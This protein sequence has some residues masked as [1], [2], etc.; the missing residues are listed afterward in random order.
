[1]TECQGLMGR[2]F[3]H[4]YQARFDYETSI[5]VGI[6]ELTVLAFGPDNCLE[7]KE[8]YRGDVCVRCGNIINQPKE[9]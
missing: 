5:P 4:K 1:M 7:S 9:K 8:T 6:T 3:G 2:I